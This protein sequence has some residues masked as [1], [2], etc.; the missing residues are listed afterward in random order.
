MAIVLGRVKAVWEQ[1]KGLDSTF[2]KELHAIVQLA[3]EER[4]VREDG[5]GNV[6]LRVVKKEYKCEE[7]FKLIAEVVRGHLQ[8]AY[9]AYHEGST[10]PL[11][12]EYYEMFLNAC[13][14]WGQLLT[15][16]GKEN[17]M[18]TWAMQTPKP[19]GRVLHAG[20]GGVSEQHAR[21]PA[22]AEM[23]ALL[24]RLEALQ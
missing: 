3:F 1:V 19:D 23:R 2:T 16:I 9:T 22:M 4:T 10:R 7:G 17:D 13:R 14:G 12:Y 21:M 11:E 5:V 18:E 6:T 8:R 15:L 24:G 20:G